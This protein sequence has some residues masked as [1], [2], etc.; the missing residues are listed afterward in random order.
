MQRS[1][2]IP[3]LLPTLKLKNEEIVRNSTLSTKIIQR[4][5][6]LIFAVV[7]DR[8]FQ[9]EIFRQNMLTLHPTPAF[10]NRTQ[11]FLGARFLPKFPPNLL[12]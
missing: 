3:R 11:K 2:D 9:V 12:I 10:C 7:Y 5:H 1:T 4:I 8:Y 6:N